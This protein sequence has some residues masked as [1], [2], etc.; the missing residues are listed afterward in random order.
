MAAG[1]RRRA[2]PSTMRTAPVAARCTRCRRSTP[3][4]LLLFGTGARDAGASSASAVPGPGAYDVTDGRYGNIGGHAVGGALDKAERDSG[5][6]RN[7]SAV[8][9]PGQY[10]VLRKPE[11][12]NESAMPGVSFPRQNRFLRDTLTGGGPGPAYLPNVLPR[13]RPPTWSFPRARR[14]HSAPASPTPGPASY[15]PARPRGGPAWLFPMAKR[16]F[17]SAAAPRGVVSPGVGAYDLLKRPR[18]APPGGSFGRAQRFG[19]D[20]RGPSTPGPGTYSPGATVLPTPRWRVRGFTIGRAARRTSDPLRS[21]AP[22]FYDV[23]DGF[24][25]GPRAVFGSAG[26]FFKGNAALTSSWPGPGEYE[27]S[28]PQS[29]PPGGIIGMAPRFSAS[30]ADTGTPAVGTYDVVRSEAALHTVP[31]G[32][33]DQQKRFDEA[34]PSSARAPG[35]GAYTLPP[36]PAGPSARVGRADRFDGRRES[37]DD[38]PVGAAE[39]TSA[40]TCCGVGRGVSFPRA[41][42]FDNDDERFAGTPG[43]GQYD[44]SRPSSAPPGGRWS[45]GERKL[46]ES[47]GA[48]ASP[49]PYL[50][51]GSFI[52]HPRATFTKAPRFGSETAEARLQDGPPLYMPVLHERVPGGAFPLARRFASDDEA[53]AWLSG[54][55]PQ[56]YYP[57][58]QSA[59]I[60]GRIGTASRFAAHRG[61]A[62]APGPSY[63]PPPWTASGRG[64]AF[65]GGGDRFGGGAALATADAPL[66]NPERHDRVAGGAMPRAERFGDARLDSRPSSADYFPRNSMIAWAAEHGAGFSIGS[67][68]AHDGRVPDT[69]PSPAD[70]FPQ[71]L[72]SGAGGAGG[73]GRAPRFGSERH[74]LDDTPGPGQYDVRNVAGVRC[75]VGVHRAA[76]A[77][78]A[79]VRGGADARPGELLSPAAACAGRWPVAE[80]ESLRCTRPRGR[81]E[82]GACSGHVHAS[83]DR[84]WACR[85]DADWLALPA[86]RRARRAEHAVACELRAERALVRWYRQR[87]GVFDRQRWRGLWPGAA[88]RAVLR[89]AQLAGA[90]DAHRIRAAVRTGGHWRGFVARAGHGDA[91]EHAGGRAGASSRSSAVAKLPRRRQHAVAGRLQRSQHDRPRALGHH[92]PRTSWRSRRRRRRYAWYVEGASVRGRRSDARQCDADMGELVCRARRLQLRAS[93]LAGRQAFAAATAAACLWTVCDSRARCVCDSVDDRERPCVFHRARTHEHG[94]RQLG[95]RHTGAGRVRCA[96]RSTLLHPRCRDHA[97][98]LRQ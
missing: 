51:H 45:A 98:A 16:S 20:A 67:A 50:A 14:L 65:G 61:D 70:Y 62:D 87:T 41:R 82:L 59:P 68:G 78:R 30:S 93:A 85:R 22:A 38:A 19:P 64:I 52:G 56:S 83:A 11:Y 2:S 35:P 58:P 5:D 80:G 34:V 43:P 57:R 73:I 37:E 77:R 31:G 40:T 76:A 53:F 63:V 3:A 74:A 81:R 49:G 9:G 4:T 29:A 95:A 71:P 47:G 7:A 60:G 86:G 8:P 72:R 75:A 88:R 23:P 10:D 21:S 27:L 24:P 15:S 12:R 55:G 92:R 89:P 90:S 54:P 32:T 26:R 46:G 33:I 69:G 13:Q 6:S 28:R 25:S 66:Y 36:L 1:A 39:A 97:T 91:S 17:D 96:G 84:S 44:V 94:R 79:H 18:S 48:S 42:R